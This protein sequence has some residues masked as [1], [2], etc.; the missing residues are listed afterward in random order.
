ML[1]GDLHTSIA[2]NVRLDDAPD[3]TTVEFMATSVTSPG[4]AEYLPERH[5]GAVAEATLKQNPDLRYMET[6]R[7]GWLH[8]TFTHDECVGEWRLLDT[9]TDTDYTVS[10]DKRLSVTAGNVAAGLQEA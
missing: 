10:V 1:S 5:P 9:I 7:R 8:M 3:V 6:D 4:F 2:G